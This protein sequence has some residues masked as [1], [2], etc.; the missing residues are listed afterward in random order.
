MPRGQSE[1]MGNL[2]KCLKHLTKYE[3]IEANYLTC[4]KAIMKGDQEVIWGLIHNLWCI[5]NGKPTYLLSQRTTPSRFSITRIDKVRVQH[6]SRDKDS[7]SINKGLIRYR[8]SA[9]HRSRSSISVP[10]MCGID[11]SCLKNTDPSKETEASLSNWLQ[12][13]NIIKPNTK[14][15][16]IDIR[17]VLIQLAHI[18]VKDKFTFKDSNIRDLRKA[19]EC[20]RKIPQINR[21]Y[22][23]Y[24]KEICEGDRKKAL[25]LLEDLHYYWKYKSV[26]AYNSP[27]SCNEDILQ[28]LIKNISINCSSENIKV[29]SIEDNRLPDTLLAWI[30]EVLD[31]TKDYEITT[32]S[33]RDGVLLANLVEALERTKI[34]RIE[35][36]PRSNAA[37]LHNIRLALEV[38]KNKKIIPLP[39]IYSEQEIQSGDNKT[40]IELLKHIKAAYNMQRPIYRHK[41]SISTFI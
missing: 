15:K 35:V 1:V 10:N 17:K 34:E 25:G 12:S 7:I 8:S 22:L 6:T 11:N 23:C 39:Y 5:Y 37:V 40:I 13:L 4:E 26:S 27:I 36:H 14:L 32:D 33:F 19:F 3:K 21:R 24:E 18:L 2:K 41:K 28:E 30:Y 38:L 20:F 9:T 31:R 29:D 16:D